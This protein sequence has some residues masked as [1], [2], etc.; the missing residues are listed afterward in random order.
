MN[1]NFRTMSTLL[2]ALVFMV[3]AQVGFSQTQNSSEGKN[4]FTLMGCASCHG[5]SGQGTHLAPNLSTRPLSQENF[6]AYVRAPVGNGNMI[7]YSEQMLADKSLIEIYAFLQSLPKPPDLVGQVS[8]GKKLY[9]KVGCYS[10]HAN[11]GQ[12]GMHGPR[13]GPDPISFARFD[14]YV[15]YP[16]AKMPPYSTHVLTQQELADIHAFLAAQP[17]PKPVSDIPL[18]KNL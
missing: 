14:W 8:K 4:K 12:G 3:M 7:A 18:L 9:T 17:Q 11:E 10:C 1:N 13:V 5:S 2:L 6:I 15:R 16:T